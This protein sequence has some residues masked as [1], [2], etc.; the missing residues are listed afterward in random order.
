M[1]RDEIK[2]HVEKYGRRRVNITEHLILKWWKIFN[3]EVFGGKLPNK[4]DKLDVRDIYCMPKSRKK[5]RKREKQNLYGYSLSDKQ[6]TL[7]INL[8]RIHSRQFFLAVLVH[9]MVHAYIDMYYP[10]RLSRCSHGKAFFTF[11]DVIGTMGLPLEI[12]Y[13][14]PFV[15]NKVPKYEEIEWA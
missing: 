6:Y 4:P 7:G 8:S 13:D 14:D 15:W 9:E 5:H 3:R 11:R 12:H 10:V 2:T 1:T